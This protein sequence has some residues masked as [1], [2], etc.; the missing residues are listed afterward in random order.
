MTKQLHEADK[1]RLNVDYT[2]LSK[3]VK[4][5]PRGKI[6]IKQSAYL[7]FSRFSTKKC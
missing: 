5:N 3:N 6:M 4:V 2:G 1:T 7:I